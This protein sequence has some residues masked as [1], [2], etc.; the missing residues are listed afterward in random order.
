[1]GTGS[2]RRN[3]ISSEKTPPRGACPPFSTAPWD[4][5]P[6]KG[7]Q[8][9]S[10]IAFSCDFTQKATEPVP[11]IGLPCLQFELSTNPCEILF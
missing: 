9:L 5:P 11:F 2:E 4:G 10:Q 8:A 7:G 3:G 1:M 6:E